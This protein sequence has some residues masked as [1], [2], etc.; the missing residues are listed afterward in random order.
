MRECSSGPQ[1]VV[2]AAIGILQMEIIGSE[3]HE[4]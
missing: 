3:E 4:D 2:D 1:S